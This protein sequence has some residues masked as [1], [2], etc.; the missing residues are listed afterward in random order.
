MV[1]SFSDE[2]PGPGEGIQHSMLVPAPD[3]DALG[4]CTSCG[5]P[6][7]AHI[8]PDGA[9]SVREFHRSFLGGNV[10]FIDEVERT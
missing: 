8:G 2:V 10:K 4:F 5:E 3:V 6:E 1:S 7:S 9:V